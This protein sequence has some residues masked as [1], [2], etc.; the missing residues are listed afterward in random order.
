[1]EVD[2]NS[3]RENYCVSQQNK[4]NVD[5]GD[6]DPPL[7]QETRIFIYDIE[8]SFMSDEYPTLGAKVNET[9]LASMTQYVEPHIPLNPPAQ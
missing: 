6:I 3:G 7:L 9:E 8:K 5:I 2:I 4:P 1:M